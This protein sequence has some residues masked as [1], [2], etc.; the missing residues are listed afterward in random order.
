[1]AAA[2]LRLLSILRSELLANAVEQLHVALLRILLE[3]G[4]ERPGHSA[5]SLAGDVGVLRRLRVF[6]AAPHDDVC[7]AGLGLLGSFVG[8]VAAG[9]LLNEAH[10]RAGHAAKIAAC[11][12]RYD[13][14]ET[15]AGFFGQVGLLENAL[16]GVDIGQIESGAGVARV[17]DGCQTNTGLQRLD[18]HTVHLVVDNVAGATEVYGVDNLV[19]TIF[20][21]AVEVGSLAAVSCDCYEQLV[22]RYS[23]NRAYLSSGRRVNRSVWRP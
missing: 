23:N 6:A 13:T 10:G 14:E 4:D 17:E 8:V 11:I 16:G 5:G 19:V 21:V 20:F 7:R 9:C 18:H 1:M 15:L 3:R 2:Q 22:L 12:R